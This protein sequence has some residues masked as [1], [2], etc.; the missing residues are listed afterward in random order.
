MVHLQWHSS[1]K[2]KKG[3]VNIA[4]STQKPTFIQ[5]GCRNALRI[6]LFADYKRIFN[7]RPQPRG[8]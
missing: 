2:K 5:T 7:E 8:K 3:R 1:M 4:I 6:S